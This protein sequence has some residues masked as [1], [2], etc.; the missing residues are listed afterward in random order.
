MVPVFIKLR[1]SLLALL[2][3]RVQD[4]LKPLIDLLHLDSV[5]VPELLRFFHDRDGL[6]HVLILK[7]LAELSLIFKKAG[8][9][10]LIKKLLKI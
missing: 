9:I 5:L 10:L 4:I 1:K 6:L 2:D 8:Q 7:P 3:I